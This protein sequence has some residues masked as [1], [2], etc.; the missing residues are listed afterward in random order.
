MS[1]LLKFKKVLTRDGIFFLGIILFVISS[2]I[3]L[4]YQSVK[5]DREYQ[6]LLSTRLKTMGYVQ[7]LTKETANLHRQMRNI[8]F[9]SDSSEIITCRK[10]MQASNQNLSK[11][12]S[13]LEIDLNDVREKKLFKEIKQVHLAYDSAYQEIDK[14]YIHSVKGGKAYEYSKKVLRPLYT[15]WQ[16][17][18][19]KLAFSIQEQAILKSEMESAKNI[20]TS[21]IILLIA[22]TPFIL[23][24]VWLAYQ[25]VLFLVKYVFRK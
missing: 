11:L 24:I 23:M 3:F 25:V 15:I 18:L 22:I 6:V 13:Q 5:M 7:S 14:Y 10:D 16:E 12:L 4:F 17:K 8:L 2:V 19:E 9:A 21:K 1:T 20:R